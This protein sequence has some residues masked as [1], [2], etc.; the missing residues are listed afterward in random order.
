MNIVLI[1]FRGT[2]KTT[3][4]KRLAEKL[5]LEFIDADDFIERKYGF[6]ISELFQTKGESLFRLLES[7]VINELSKLDSRIIAAGGGAVLKYKN[8]KNLKRHGIIILLEADG[9][10]VYQRIQADDKT[11]TQRPKLTGNEL[12]R[13]IKEL[14]EFRKSYYQRAADYT[15]NTTNKSADTTLEEI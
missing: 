12:Y 2:G 4:G 11:K 13:E 9:D 15:V 14:M 8:I 3:V 7:D 6:S 1:G 5:N 10:T